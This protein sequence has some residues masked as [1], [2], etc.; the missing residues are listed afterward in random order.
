MNC[1]LPVAKV[2]SSHPIVLTYVSK[3]VAS[4][5][6]LYQATGTVREPADSCRQEVR[7]PTVSIACTAHAHEGGGRVLFLFLF[8]PFLSFVL[9]EENF[10]LHS[11]VWL[12]IF[13]CIQRFGCKFSV[14]IPCPSVFDCMGME[15]ITDG[16]GI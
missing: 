4:C 13:A 12:R 1:Q 15:R 16:H 9:M 6:F 10:R 5:I 2:C 11:T 8:F 3:Q 14:T 7:F